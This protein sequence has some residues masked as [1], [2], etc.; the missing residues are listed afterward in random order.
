MAPEC[1][2]LTR[3]KSDLTIEGMNASGHPKRWRGYASV[4]PLVFPTPNN[5]QPSIHVKGLGYGW[6]LSRN[7]ENAAFGK[8]TETI[9]PCDD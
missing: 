2:Q 6:K 5:A 9:K 7:R 1:S 3:W 8:N 4:A